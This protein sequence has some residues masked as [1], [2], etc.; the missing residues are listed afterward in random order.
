MSRTWREFP[1]SSLAKTSSILERARSP[2]HVNM[3]DRAEL[4]S[5]SSQVGSTPANPGTILKRVL[6]FLSFTNNSHESR[7]VHYRYLF[8]SSSVGACSKPLRQPGRTALANCF[9]KWHDLTGNLLVLFCGSAYSENLR[10][11]PLPPPGLLPIFVPFRHRCASTRHKI[12]PLWCFL[13]HFQSKGV[14][15][16]V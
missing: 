2:G 9:W 8:S 3:L 14:D 1:S 16:S 11:F 5:P 7:S 6:S 4:S 10:L 12:S 13:T 15:I